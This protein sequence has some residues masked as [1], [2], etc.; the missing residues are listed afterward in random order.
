MSLATKLYEKEIHGVERMLQ[1]RLAVVLCC[2]ALALA[3]ACTIFTPT[4][5]G[6]VGDDQTLMLGL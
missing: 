5:I 3:V 2:I 6:N 1:R 4:A